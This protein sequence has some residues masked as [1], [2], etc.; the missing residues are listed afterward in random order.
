MGASSPPRPWPAPRA[1]PL[2]STSPAPQNSSCSAAT[3]QGKQEQRRAH[4][5]EHVGRSGGDVELVAWVL[6]WMEAT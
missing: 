4:G 3:S 2:Q 5:E 1:V 6:D